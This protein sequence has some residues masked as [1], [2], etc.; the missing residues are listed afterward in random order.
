MS[1]PDPIVFRELP[2]I[3][4]IIRD[5]TWLEGERRGCAVAAE[6]PIVQ[7]HVCDV[8]L[9]VG[10]QLRESFMGAPESGLLPP[11]DFNQP[12]ESKA[13]QRDPGSIRRACTYS[14]VTGKI[15]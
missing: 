6:D 11:G 15:R 10:Q 1:F 3:E 12:A 7:T 5:E 4:K 2:V 8:I 13:W 9:R 14:G